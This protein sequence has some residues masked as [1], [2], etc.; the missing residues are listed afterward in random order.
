[1]PGEVGAAAEMNASPRAARRPRPGWQAGVAGS[2]MCRG[3]RL[4]AIGDCMTDQLPGPGTWT[5][6]S[7]HS[8]VEFTVEHF[9]VAFARGIAAGPTGS[10]TIADDLPASSAR[11]SVDV[12][13]LTTANKVR[14]EKILGPDV[15]DAAQFPTIDFA[16]GALRAADG[17]YQLDGDLTLHGIT[18]PVTLALTPHGVI[19]DVWGKTRLGLTA[20]T[21]IQRSD[22]DVL[23]WGHVA[24]A[25][26]GFMVPDAV[27]VTLEIEAVRDEQS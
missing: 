25:A 10:I 5:I 16:S 21:Q 7:A 22:F 2:K 8:W 27:R 4:A 6:D 9:T 19:T 14:D 18:R 26:G 15:L 11:A 24:L 13:T 3:N 1:V 20:T 12:S 23:K 17:G